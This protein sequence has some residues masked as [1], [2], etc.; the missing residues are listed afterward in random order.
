MA[1]LTYSELATALGITVGSAKNLVRRK[2]WMRS[3]G[4][5]GAARIAVPDEY[6][7]EHRKSGIGAG[8]D[9][10][11]NP[12][13]DGPVPSNQIPIEVLDTLREQ[14]VRL[15]EE[16]ERLN[17]AAETLRTEVKSLTAHKAKHESAEIEIQALR[18]QVEWLSQ[19]WIARLIK[20]LKR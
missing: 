4:N 11:I 16:N 12:P 2:R 7:I 17:K 9:G 14:I 10:D 15:S 13:H 6:L 3:N 5:D 1:S 19:P 20:S 18:S 8:T